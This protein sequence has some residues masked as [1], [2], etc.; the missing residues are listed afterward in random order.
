MNTENYTPLNRAIQERTNPSWLQI[1]NNYYPLITQPILRTNL[2][3]IYY[4]LS[5]V[6]DTSNQEYCMVIILKQIQ[7]SL[8]TIFSSNYKL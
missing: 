7:K 4:T 8:K 1:F 6:V 5:S 3:N 2:T